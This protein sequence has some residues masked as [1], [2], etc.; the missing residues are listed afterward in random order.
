MRKCPGGQ[1]TNRFRGDA[2]P[3][4]GVHNA[5]ADLDVTFKIGRSVKSSAPDEYG[6]FRATL[7]KNVPHPPAKLIG[8]AGE[9]CMYV[10]TGGGV[11]EL[12]RPCATLCAQQL[13]K[14]FVGSLALQ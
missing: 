9:L 5:V 7:E 2:H 10:G 11:M 8:V 4:I 3:L 13:C 14:R 6:N 12:G 1:G